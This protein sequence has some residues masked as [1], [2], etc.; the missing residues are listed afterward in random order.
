LSWELTGP[1]KLG[2]KDQ[3]LSCLQQ[4]TVTVRILCIKKGTCR[5]HKPEKETAVYK[6]DFSRSLHKCVSSSCTN[7][8]DVGFEILTA[9]TMKSTIFWDVMLCSLV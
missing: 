6:V 9:V 5:K 4:S 8:Y 3:H 2:A 7:V 1:G